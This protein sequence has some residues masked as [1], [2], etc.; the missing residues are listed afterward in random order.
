MI[1]KLGLIIIFL[2]FAFFGIALSQVVEDGWYLQ[3]DPVISKDKEIDLPPC[4]TER[5]VTVG[6]GEGH[7]S[8]NRSEE[9]F[10]EGSGTYE[11]K[12]TW[13][14]PPKFLKP[15]KIINLAMTCTSPL[16]DI[17]T[18]GLIGYDNHTILEGR[19]TNP[20]GKSTGSFIVPDAS[21]GD[22]MAI[23]AKFV[24]ISGLH[25]DVV[26]NYRYLKAGEY[27]ALAGQASEK[28]DSKDALGKSDRETAPAREGPE[29]NI[30]KKALDEPIEPDDRKSDGK[31][32][33]QNDILKTISSSIKKSA[34]NSATASPKEPVP[35]EKKA[36]AEKD[37]YSDKSAFSEQFAEPSTPLKILSQIAT[38]DF[39][40]NPQN[41]AGLYYDLDSDTGAE[42]I[43]TT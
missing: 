32:P 16:A 25:G 24:A 14:V 20:E 5:T 40:W 15:G 13:T 11:S 35:P 31:E 1:K 34:K 21:Y 28:K 39:E 23:Y 9:C 41:F 10:M 30:E 29:E 8:V 26:Y 42:S 17:P 27:A 6:D 18:S 22:E 38:G 36:P 12:V 7:G 2:L 37:A 33:A 43:T 4:Y 19:S 3:G